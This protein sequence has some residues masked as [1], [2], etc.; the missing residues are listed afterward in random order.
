MRGFSILLVIWVNPF[1]ILISGLNGLS[2]LMILSN[3]S[4]T[5]FHCSISKNLLSSNSLKLHGIRFILI[6]LLL[7]H[8][9]FFSH[10]LLSFQVNLINLALIESFEVIWLHSVWGQHT[11]FSGLI[12][13]HEVVI[14]CLFNLFCFLSGPQLVLCSLSISFLLRHILINIIIVLLVSSSLL[15][16]ILL[17]VFQVLVE[18]KGLFIK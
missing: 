7:I 8:L 15:I 2:H 1:L 13:G 3:T 16:M 5:S 9:L 14:I 6:F 11:G 12:F 18:Q 17:S 10:L 4:K